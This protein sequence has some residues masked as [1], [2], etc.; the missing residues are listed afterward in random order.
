M[1]YYIIIR[2]PLG[3]GKTA[4]AGRITKLVKGRYFSIDKIL[5]EHGLLKEWEEG[6]I[7]QK[8]FIRV[9]G[10]VAPKAE[11]LLSSGIPVVFDGNFYWKSQIDD[12]IKR[13]DFP[14]YVFTL[15]VPLEI[16]VKRDR[17]RN[18]TYGKKSAEDVYK[19]SAEFNYGETIDATKPL[20][21][22]VDDILSFLPEP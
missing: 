19:K 20:K 10:I 2:G 14:H 9:N 1:S 5:N 11:K 17:E 8:S 3:C 18:K 21:E 12:L 6:Y 4:V 15:Q 7:S 22:V 16:C 13:L